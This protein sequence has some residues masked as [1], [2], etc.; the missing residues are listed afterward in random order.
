MEFSMERRSP[1]SGPKRNSV[2][3]SKALRARCRRRRTG[4]FKKGGR[5]Q[6]CFCHRSVFEKTIPIRGNDVILGAIQSK[7]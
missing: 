2:P 1:V 5:G 3:R 6:R 4:R 7:N